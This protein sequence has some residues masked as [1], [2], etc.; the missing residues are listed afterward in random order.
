MVRGRVTLKEWNRI[1][2][3]A[4]AGEW[5]GGGRKGKSE[6]GREKG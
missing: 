3:M 1:R 2:A 6:G 4:G 5:N